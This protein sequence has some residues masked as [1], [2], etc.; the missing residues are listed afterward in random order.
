MSMRRSVDAGAS[1]WAAMLILVPIFNFVTMLY[2][3]CIQQDY[4]KREYQLRRPA[5]KRE[6]QPR[7]QTK[8]TPALDYSDDEHIRNVLGLHAILVSLTIGFCYLFAMFFLSI[9]L[10]ESYGAVLF[11]G[12]PI[13]AGAASGYSYNRWCP[14]SI[15]STAGLSVFTG[16]F[17]AAGL[18]LLGLEGMVCLAMAAPIMLPLGLLG[19]LVGRAV[20]IERQKH[21][22]KKDQGLLGCLL[23]LP[24]IAGIEPHVTLLPEYEVLTSIDIAASPAEV[25]DLAVDFPPITSPDPWYFRWGIASPREA[26]IDGQGVG[27]IRYCKFTTGEFVEPIT[28]WDESHRLVFDVTDQPE[29]MTELSPYRHVHPPHLDSSFR[30]THGEF[31]LIELPGGHTRLEGRTWYQI[32]MGPIAYWTLWTDALIHRIHLRVLEHIQQRAEAL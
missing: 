30:S 16:A 28:V 10:F 26:T 23:V 3:A 4:A 1:P 18:L 12:T 21:H 29:P 14:R 8:S 32:D 24:L 19:A 22:H 31:R 7:R 15:A 2:L 20:A 25:W 27:A 5:K 11:Y 17:F 13:I 9:Y 6:Y